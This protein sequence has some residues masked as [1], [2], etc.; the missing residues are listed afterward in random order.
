M[1]QT[2]LDAGKLVRGI[3]LFGFTVY[4]IKLLGSGEIYRLVAPYIANLLWVTLGCFLIL[5]FHTLSRIYQPVPAHD[6]AGHNHNLKPNLGWAILTA[7]VVL[8]LT[9]PTQSLGS[10]MIHSALTTQAAQSVAPIGKVST[11]NLAKTPAPITEE[12]ID[13]ATVPHADGDYE[14][15]IRRQPGTDLPLHELMSNILIAP[16]Y[17]YNQTYQY[18]GFVYHPPGWPQNRLVLLRYMISC[19]AAD[20][21]PIGV[22]VE[23]KD[24]DKIPADQW[25]TVSGVLSTR[26]IPDANTIVPIAWYQGS[27]Q[28]PTVIAS[29]ITSIK[30][31]KDPYLN[32]KIK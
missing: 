20:A 25:L 4:L 11:P 12:K 26:K 10:S 30:E 13:L 17:Y 6:H 9:L 28:K 31:P 19:C 27:E 2:R 14:K 24:A 5:T 29:T 3:I 8:G 21:S 18:T 7:P 22:S 32:T 16:E 15:P 1:K 23:W